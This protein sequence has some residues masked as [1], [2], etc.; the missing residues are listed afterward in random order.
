MKIIPRWYQHECN[1]ALWDYFT[2]SGGNPLCA[3]PTGTGKSVI[4]AMFLESIFRHYPRQKILCLTHVK[5]LIQQ[6]FAKL[7]HLWPGAP[8]GINSASL[9]QRDV[10]FPIIFAGIGSVAKHFASF[11]NV[12]LLI[13]DEA[14]LVSPD[15]ETMYQFFIKGLKSMNPQLKVIGFTATPWR[16]GQGKLTEGG[17]FT[18]V[19]YDLTGMEAF[20]RL[21]AEGYLCKL[22]PKPTKTLLDV[23]G[24]H[25][26]GGEYIA[27]ELQ[28]AIN[29]DDV[30]RAALREALD[31][32]SSRKHWL[33]F[34]SG[35]EH[36]INV[37]KMLQLFGEPN[38]V[39]HS[40]MGDYE[41]DKAID[42]YRSGKVRVAVNNNILTTGFD[43]PE[44]DFIPVLTATLSS[45]KWV[46]MLGRGTRPSVETGKLDCL[47][48]DY[49]RNT[50]KLGPINDPVI[51]RKKGDKPGV[52]PIKQCE[53]CETYNHASV[54]YCISCGYEFP[55]IVK[56]KREASTDELIKGDIPITEVFEVDHVTVAEHK[57]A[58]KPLSMKLSYYCISGGNIMPRFDEY[59]CV[60]HDG[61]AGNK[62]KH[63]WKERSSEPMP[64]TTTEA[65]LLVDQLKMAT[66]LRVWTNKHPYPE[67]MK[68]CL[69]GTAF[70]TLKDKVVRSPMIEKQFRTVRRGPN[71]V[72][73]SAAAEVRSAEAA[74][75]FDDDI[76]F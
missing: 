73:N 61:P 58:G 75:A 21:I 74:N 18:D 14:H 52:A 22:I 26:R 40:K 29:R 23:S 55:V 27:G 48:G 15:E 28:S 70:G 34:A 47:V 1:D 8:V 3:L 60:E 9:G 17:I 25:T 7:I 12:D 59:V 50:K 72:P 42:A 56:L 37:G 54:R 67:I 63:W 11:G 38:V 57:K 10:H 20:N 44:I 35:V 39:V 41:R 53:M 45:A 4:I 46:Q 5:E 2:H 36:A 32:G 65:I 51:P 6:N 16:L 49:A 68:Q 24:V 66:H 33:I 62:A 31:I 69:D 19:C 13:I 43:F 71:V 64:K 76:P 30:T